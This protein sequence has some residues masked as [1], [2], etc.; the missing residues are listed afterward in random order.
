MFGLFE[1]KSC[2]IC[3]KPLDKFKWIIDQYSVRKGKSKKQQNYCRDHFIEQLQ[4]AINT[5]EFPMILSEPIDYK[6]GPINL[7]QWVYYPLGDLEIDNFTIDDQKSVMNLLQ[8]TTDEHPIIWIDRSVI[9][10]VTT[11]P[12]FKKS[13]EYEAISRNQA[14]NRI[15]SSFY[16]Y[17]LDQKGEFLT[18]L[19]YDSA[20]I[21]IYT[22][23]I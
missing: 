3:H 13:N 23:Y 12:I 22:N 7:S 8:F 5:F 19:P 17:N 4:Q 20:G 9:Q 14:L 15:K 10:E 2:A 11:S 16:E 6:D 1:P 21:F 18:N